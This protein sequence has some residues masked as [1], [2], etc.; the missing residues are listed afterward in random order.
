MPSLLAPAF[1]LRFLLTCAT[2][3]LVSRQASCCRSWG[4]RSPFVLRMRCTHSASRQVERARNVGASI[5]A[6][7]LGYQSWRLCCLGIAAC[8][9]LKGVPAR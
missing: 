1:T 2:Y 4:G 3:A 5:V 8:E 7:M 9:R 6:A